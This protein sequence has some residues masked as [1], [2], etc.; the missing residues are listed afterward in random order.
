MESQRKS[1]IKLRKIYFFTTTIY[2][3]Q[4]LLSDKENKE[5]IVSYLKEVIKTCL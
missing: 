3:W 2:K 1:V 4:Y 5:Q